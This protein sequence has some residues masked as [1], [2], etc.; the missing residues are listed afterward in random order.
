M[1]EGSALADEF[2]AEQYAEHP[3]R[4]DRNAGPEIER[5]QDADDA[6][7]QDPAPV[8]KG[9][10]RQCKNH[11]RNALD[12]EEHDQE[13]RE[14]EQ[15]FARIAQEQRS[16]QDEQ[17][18]RYQLQPEMRHVARANQTDR[19]QY[20]ADDQQPSEEDDHGDRRNRGKDQRQNAGHNHQATLDEIPERMP[21]DRFA[22]RLAHHLGGGFE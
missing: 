2:D 4:A 14:R 1:E 20:A 10:Y 5:Q 19:L 22:H 21:L 3:D 17:D 13:K 6:A 18:H 8:R 15:A 12:H 16:D 9:P 7:A 11:L